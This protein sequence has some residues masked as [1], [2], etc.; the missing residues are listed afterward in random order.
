V[1]ATPA[2]GVRAGRIGGHVARV[3]SGWQSVVRLA[4]PKPAI[5]LGVV[6]WLV[7]GIAPGANPASAAP[8]SL[9]LRGV[10]DVRAAIDSRN[11]S[12][13]VLST[14]RIRNTTSA[15]VSR[16]TFNLVPLRIGHAQVRRVTVD[17]EAVRPRV[18]GQSV[19]VALPDRLAPGAKTRVTIRYRAV[20]NKSTGGKRSL[21]A[22]SDGVIT[23][24]RWIPWL[25]RAQHFQAGNLG[26]TWV[27][28]VSPRVT[29]T[30]RHDAPLDF[31]TSGRSVHRTAHSRKF[32]ATNVRDFNFTASAAYRTRTVSWR[33]V[34]VTV[35]YLDE[36][37]ARL[38]K[39]TLRA[40]KRFTDRIGP[41][42]YSR[43]HVAETPAG[44]GM[45][46]PA[47][48]WIDETLPSERLPYVVAHEVAHQ[49]FYGAVGNNQARS[50]FVDEA[51]ADFLA[52]DLLHDFRASACAVDR[53][54]LAVYDY[55][56]RCYPEVI[57]IQGGLYLRSYKREV[58]AADFWAGLRAFYDA[59][60]FRV[61]G[62]RALLDALDHASGF[63]S[64]RHAA[65]FP[66]LYR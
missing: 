46:S 13:S 62:T 9:P 34:K 24:Y 45:E 53:L 20:F 41:Y 48:T 8:N 64:S 42:P 44:V 31:A 14:A 63:D 66:S 21:F 23:A 28:A 33:H 2:V 36:P 7:V 54:D 56:A 5:A 32:V 58:G 11:G 55:S 27:T 50:P 3:V 52:R 17:G 1:R 39:W 38:L 65:R 12:L 15:S 26:E 6:A 59:A 57:Y 18:A 37:P 61:V 10:Y 51:V 35:H 60:R 19:Q 4:L 43:L 30:I 40:L 22:M 49:W 47:L 25:S 29:V 16:L